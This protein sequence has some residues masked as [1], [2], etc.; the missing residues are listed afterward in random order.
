MVSIKRR[1]RDCQHNSFRASA[2]RIHERKCLF[3][4]WLHQLDNFESSLLVDHTFV[5][6]ASLLNE[7]RQCMDAAEDQQD[8]YPGISPD[9]LQW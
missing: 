4:A 3:T 7:T 8:R 1:M 9:G 2:R 5:K 6:A